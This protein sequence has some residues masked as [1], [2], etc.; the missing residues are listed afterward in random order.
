MKDSQNSIRGIN[1]ETAFTVFKPAKFYVCPNFQIMKSTLGCVLVLLSFLNASAQ[2]DA[3]AQ[4]VLKGVSAKYKSLKS[5]SVKFNVNVADPKNKTNEKQSGT[6]LIK[7][8]KYKLVLG[9][10][11]IYC[12]SKTVW[13]YLK[14]AA[15]VQ[16]NEPK[17]DPNAITPT[18]IFTIYEKGFKSKFMGE[19]SEKG[20][21]IQSIELVPEDLKKSYFKVQLSINKTEKIITQ[22]K[23][24]QRDGTTIG[25][26]IDSFT[27]SATADDHAFVF[28]P[29]KYPGV[30]VI[31]LR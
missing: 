21:T 13:T 26:A 7:G 20:K 27:P 10:Q 9:T 8:Q 24:F 12:D 2:V 6:I 5:Y 25:Y 22:A 31:D 28:D 4:E 30:E 1:F 3:K 18:S 15:E 17:T 29:K 19:K 11:E 23:I 16:V 14:D